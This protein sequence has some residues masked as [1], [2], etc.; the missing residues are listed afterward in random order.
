MLNLRIGAGLMAIVVLLSYASLQARSREHL[1]FQAGR[2]FSESS[3]TVY[4]GDMLYF[5]NND[6]VPHNVTS[7]SNGNEFDLGEQAPG[8]AT[9]VTWKSVV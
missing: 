1:V 8:I 6:D 7:T 3:L 4:V 5:M 2:T 9:P